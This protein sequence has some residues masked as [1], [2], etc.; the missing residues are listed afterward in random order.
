M[1]SGA[2]LASLQLLCRAS[3]SWVMLIFFLPLFIN[4]SRKARFT[5]TIAYQLLGVA[6][7]NNRDT[8][9]YSHYTFFL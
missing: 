4:A 9:G 8:R 2:I 6:D 7:R 5:P 3:V 1:S